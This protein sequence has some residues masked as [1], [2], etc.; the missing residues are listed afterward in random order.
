MRYSVSSDVG[1]E[2]LDIALEQLHD[3]LDRALCMVERELG[4]G[5][6]LRYSALAWAA[7]IDLDVVLE[8][9]DGVQVVHNGRLY[10]LSAREWVG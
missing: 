4:I 8:M 2:V 7:A 3:E 1:S 10:R 5:P 6:Q 9:L